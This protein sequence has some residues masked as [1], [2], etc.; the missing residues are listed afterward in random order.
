MKRS[1]CPSYRSHSRIGS[2]RAPSHRTVKG[3]SAG[4]DNESYGTATRRGFALI[5]PFQLSV[6]RLTIV[7]AL[8]TL[9]IVSASWA[10]VGSDPIAPDVKRAML[11]I[12]ETSLL[13]LPGGLR[14]T[15]DRVSD[16]AL[17]STRSPDISG[18]SPNEA[19]VRF[20]IRPTYFLLP[21]S[22]IKLFKLATELE[23]NWTPVGNVPTIVSN[24]DDGYSQAG[25]TAFDLNQAYG[26]LAHDKFVVLLGLVRSQFGLG[27]VANAGDDP[28][29]HSVRNSPYGAR[30]GGDRY[31]RAQVAYLPMGSRGKPSQSTV[32]LAIMV[33]VDRVFVDDTSDWD[34]A[35]DTRQVGGGLRVQLGS[36][37]GT[38][39]GVMRTQSYGEGGKTDVSIGVVSAAYAHDLGANLKAFAETEWAIYSGESTLSQSVQRP[40]PMDVL[41]AGGI[42]RL[43]IEH[44]HIQGVL[45]GGYASG[46]NNGFDRESH[47]FRFDS[48][49]RVGYLLY[50]HALRAQTAV[51]ASNISDPQYRAVS[52]R[53]SDTI[54]T[55]GALENSV[56]INPRISGRVSP[57][58]S[59]HAGYL[60]AHTAAVW[61]DAYR[62][63]LNGGTPTGHRGGT[64]GTELGSE[65]NIGFDYSREMGPIQMTLRSWFAWLKPGDVFDTTSGE[66]MDNVMG[67]G[68]SLELRW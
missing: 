38:L 65:A 39:G 57:H 48:N 40:E 4:I 8:V 59:V 58:F 49:Y 41:A 24:Q 42:L 29:M 9:S 56:Y 30:R 34:D 55:R 17:T 61:V 64:H 67:G 22:G 20:R 50:Q 28:K 62:S 16:V 7:H 52:P 23:F 35:D 63:A 21:K 10:Q 33:A 60:I 26:L 32:P 6:S 47:T 44:R 27:L 25:R 13:A 37:T 5:T 19:E 1:I 46:D 15:T 18:V 36:F 3:H 53:G 43:G 66:V 54:P 31:L 45:E 2:A 68:C 14:L 11:P 12:G 51:S